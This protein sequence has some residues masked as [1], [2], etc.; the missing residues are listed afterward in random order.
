MSHYAVAVFADDYNDFDRL[1]A[2]YDEGSHYQRYVCDEAD[3]K[4]KYRKFLIQNP[5][6]LELGFEYYLEDFGYKREG[7]EIAAY[8]NPNAKWDYYTLDGKSYM[9]DLTSAAQKRIDE[10]ELEYDEL[11]MKDYDLDKEDSDVDENY[12]VRFWDT[13]VEKG[14][15]MD[16]EETFFTLF[17]PDY[18]KSR[19]C[20]RENYIRRQKQVVP[21]AFVTPDGAWHAPGN[22]GWFACDDSTKETLDQ[23]TD[24]WYNY[25]H[26]DANPYVNFV[27]CHI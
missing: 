18:Y 9:F 10:G 15:K 26:S 8:Y 20:T 7:N 13:Y 4:E 2:P 19:Y 22:V 23:Y 14:E 1:L 3:L 24:D 25:I 5:S 11:R 27:D 17:T 6:W 16:G 12:L 21:Y